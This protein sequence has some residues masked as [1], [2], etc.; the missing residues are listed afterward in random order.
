MFFPFLS[1]RQGSPGFVIRGTLGAMTPREAAQSLF[2]PEA[3]DSPHRFYAQLRREAPVVEVGSSGVFLV[4]TAAL[5]EQAL[6]R[7][8]DLSSH[9]TGLLLTEDGG[10]PGVFDM[11]GVGESTDVLA[12][13]D[14]PE[15]AAHRRV[16]QPRLALGQVVRLEP[17]LRE[18]AR[19][20]TRAFVRRE[21]DYAAAVADPLPSEVTSRLLGFPAADLARIQH[22]AMQGG[23]MLAGVI[24]RAELGALAAVSAE[25]GAYLA[26]HF[27]TSQGNAEA[28]AGAPLLDALLSAVERGEMT[29]RT[30]VG[31]AVILVGAGGESTAAWIG[32]AVRILAEQPG[33]QARLRADP[34][35]VPAFLE[36]ALRLEPP[37][38]FHY[39]HVKRTTVLGG[40]T[41]RAG[42]RACLLWASA[43]RDEAAHERPNDVDLARVRLRDHLSFGRGIHFCVGA[44]L[45]RLEARIAIE[46][47][48][49]ATDHFSLDPARPPRRTRS[50]FIG[51]HEALPLRRAAAR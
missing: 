50:I 8:E 15:H 26:R 2:A 9:L 17:W 43:N 3:V 39:R 1:S 49:A 51:R 16:V 28:R 30:A 42:S 18:R 10:E 19:E 25:H 29:L 44:A 48:L 35:L 4:A 46:E 5:V 32:N 20:R 7:A 6:A 24:S 31:I 12:T 41:L 11:S 38:R 22:W 34:A 36:E 47:L 23:A 37:F 45:A 21:H 13:A 27:A 40:V 14:D 33:L